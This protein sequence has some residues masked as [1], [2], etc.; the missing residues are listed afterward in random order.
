MG[1]KATAAV[2]ELKAE[3]RKYPIAVAA[4]TINAR[5]K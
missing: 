5:I 3:E 2:S 4:W 1:A